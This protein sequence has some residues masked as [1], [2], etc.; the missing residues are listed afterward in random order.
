MEREA[1]IFLH[2]PI[3]IRFHEAPVLVKKRDFPWQS[4]N[5]NHSN[6]PQASHWIANQNTWNQ[7][8]WEWDSQKF[9]A[10][11]ASDSP[12]LPDKSVKVQNVSKKLEVE[13]QN[14]ALKL[15]VAEEPVVRPCKRV[16]AGS[17]GSSGNY[18]MCQ[19]DDCKTD[20]SNAKDYH[21][22]HKV[23][24]IHSKCSKAVVGN[25]VQRF[26]QQCSRFHPLSEFDEGKRS[27]R[28]RLAGHNRRRRKTQ[29]EDVSS[30]NAPPINTVNN[31]ITNSNLDIVNLLS[32]I[33]NLQGN[34]ATKQTDSTALPDKES[35]I[36]LISKINTISNNSSQKSTGLDLNVALSQECVDQSCKT[37]EHP[38]AA[39]TVDL[40]KV[41]S[42][43]VSNPNALTSLSQGSSFSSGDDKA[44]TS[45]DAN[46][47][48]KQ[49]PKQNFPLQLFGSG[50]DTSPPNF[51]ASVKYFS[52]E[53]SNPMED[54]S[55]SCSPPA[56]QKLFPIHS[57]IHEK[58]ERM[59]VF[60][61]DDDNMVE[62]STSQEWNTRLELF[63]ESNR[64][65]QNNA[66]H[67][68]PY[69]GGGYASSSL[70]NHSP[71]SSS[72]DAQDRTGRIIFK[73]FDKDPSK[74]PTTLRTQIVN[75]LA[76]SPSEME[77]YIRP[78]C[79]VLSIYA[80]MPS[81]GW[82]ELEEDL[83]QRV[84]SLVEDS[85]SEFWKKGRF[86][87]RT[88]KQLASHKDGKIRLCKSW[89]TWSA[90][91]VASVS[92]IAVVSGQETSL[93]LKGRNLTVPG[94]KIHCTFMGRYTSK[95]VL[96]PVHPG[97]VYDDSSFES[98]TFPG[99]FPSEFGRCFIEVENGFKGNNFPII[100]ANSMI[101][102]ELRSLESEFDDGTRTSDVNSEDQIRYTGQLRSREDLLHF[103][104]E[105]GWLFQ[106]K[107][108]QDPHSLEFSATRFKFL[109]TFSVERDWTVLIKMLLD[110]LVEKSLNC[111]VLTQESLEMLLETQLLS[112]AVKRKC[113]KMVDLLLNYYVI[114]DSN[115]RVRLFT[116]STVGPGGLT[117]LHIAASMDDSE[118]IVDSLTND[119]EKIGMN[120]W[121]S[122]LDESGQTPYMYASQRNNHSYNKLVSRKLVDKKNGQVSINI[123]NDTSMDKSW[124]V[125][126]SR[127][128]EVVCSKCAFMEKVRGRPMARARG[129][130]GRPYVHSM[131]AIAAVCVCVCLLFR[132]SPQI[133]SVAPFKWENLDF[134]PS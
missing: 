61:E 70:S 25:H 78:G 111:E 8:L 93:V 123:A 39:S 44:K 100:I 81:I 13:G 77:S 48:M 16:R 4:Q 101:C 29:P 117:P 24:D 79:V 68:N 114:K 84:S 2:Q 106:R 60:R 36:Q 1:P 85:Q 112:Q 66:G 116:P 21:R 17:P 40:L 62:L 65:A 12:E 91:E 67:N 104:N 125:P 73:L 45:T 64:R 3:P 109:L 10:K 80:S 52:S 46:M 37:N 49:P 42:A 120:C 54:G 28:R 23:C 88:S 50:E 105:L 20:L 119:P 96:G 102:Q 5:V 31:N 26:C 110:T 59:S 43:A 71:S 130:L 126:D 63:N 75:W 30:K 133:G 94:T 38:T 27:C 134:G 9:V 121:D 19:V 98:L 113:R 124:I 99:G 92:P 7:N 103:L 57:T 107:S 122:I 58:H 76:H 82:D 86:L 35:L 83:H 89:K 131:L 33:T 90:P 41:L 132:G 69:Q 129:L 14:L 6:T 127:R 74:I 97:T 53:C 118:D 18:P 32:I 47:T 11:S 34:N 108:S 87:V 115:S 95:D 15:G 72:S 128:L 55:P 22:R 51:A 56:V